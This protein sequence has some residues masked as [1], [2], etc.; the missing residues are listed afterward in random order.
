MTGFGGY[1]RSFSN[2]FIAMP[3]GPAT[4]LGRIGNASR[5]AAYGHMASPTAGSDVWEGGG[6][7]P[8]LAA[9]ST[10]EILSSSAADAA[11]GTGGRTAVI[12]GLGHNFNPISETITLNGVTPVSTANQYLRINSLMLASAGSGGT[13][14]GTITLR[15]QG[16]GAT[17][18]VIR[19]GYGYAK[20]AVYT[21]PLGFTLLVMDLYFN[22]GG[23][24]NASN[25]VFSFARTNPSGLLLITNEYNANASAPIQRLPNMGGPVQQTIS[26]T[27]RITTVGSTPTDAYAAFEGYLIDNTQLT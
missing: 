9:A 6:A 23:N 7:Y 16:A 2:D 8:F 26:L 15:V 4:T 20:S 21:V 5:A 13:N 19:I 24:G 11:A 3:A 14:A 27:T 18:S 22:V 12:N 10:L 17:Q 25:I 1:Q